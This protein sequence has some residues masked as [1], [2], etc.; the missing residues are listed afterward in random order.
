MYN[1]NKYYNLIVFDP[2]FK[3]RCLKKLYCLVI[4]T[5]NSTLGFKRE[6]YD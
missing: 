6:R 5:I 4:Q 1:E 2:R 3:E